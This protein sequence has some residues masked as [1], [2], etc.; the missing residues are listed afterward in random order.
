MDIPDERGF[1]TTVAVLDKGYGGQ[2]MYDECEGR[3]VR[4]V[5]ALKDIASVKAGK[6]LP[7]PVIMGR[8]RSLV[9]TPS[10]RQRNGAAQPESASQPPLGSRPTVSTR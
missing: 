3:D 6:H 10:A 8:G 7:R 4:P 2:P 9:P 1:T 5:S